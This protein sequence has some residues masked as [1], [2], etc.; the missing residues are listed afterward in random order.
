[1][2]ANLTNLLYQAIQSLNIEISQEQIIIEKP[3]LIE[4][5]DFSTNIAMLLAKPLKKNPREIAENIINAITQNDF[6]NKIE[7]A[8]AGFINFYLNND[9]LVSLIQNICKKK[10]TFGSNQ[11]GNNQ[12][13][14][15]EFVSANPTGP[16]H[17]GHGR[18]AA[19]GD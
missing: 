6:F 17:V 13:I 14:Q 10:D 8:G 2:K 19:I 15:I 1:M 11:Q 4:H 16:L 12:K 5:G 9:V 18:G 3:K 7:I